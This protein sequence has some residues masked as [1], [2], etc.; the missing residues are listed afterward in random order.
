MAAGA[1]AL[2]LDHVLASVVESGALSAHFTR[3][4]LEVPD[5][6]RLSL[7]QDGDTAVGVYFGE[8]P[9][10]PGRTYTVRH[11]DR[12]NARLVVD[13]LMHGEGV[14]TAWARGVPIGAKV[15][16]AHANSWYRPPAAAEWQV[17]VADMA[18]LPALARILDDPP[19]IPTTVI[20]DVVA[21]GDLAYLPQ[22]RDVTLVPL[23]GTGDGRFAVRQRVAAHTERDGTGY[24]W[25][26]GEA[27]E[28]RAA[29][30]HLRHELRWKPEQLDVMGYWRRDSADWDR[31]FARVGADLYSAYTAALADGM[32]G[33]DAF[34]AYDDALEQAGL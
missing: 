26:A 7:P 9:A 18:G 24:C 3:V 23:S 4:V 13:I 1:Q 17:L 8:S 5:V 12:Q 20:V 16:L 27:G 10:A 21:D 32:S 11:D 25:F 30:K 31:R 2:S 34:E 14:G 19:S 29:R 15:I 6:D 33:K 22:Q 28:A